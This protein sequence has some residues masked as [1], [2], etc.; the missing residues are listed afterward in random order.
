MRRPKRWG[1]AALLLGA[2]LPL[3]AWT[4]DDVSGLDAVSTTDER[5]DCLD[6]LELDVGEL[7]WPECFDDPSKAIG[8]RTRLRKEGIL[9]RVQQ[10]GRWTRVVRYFPLSAAKAE[11]KGQEALR[12]RPDSTEGMLAVVVDWDPDLR[13]FVWDLEAACPKGWHAAGDFKLTAYV[14]A[15]EKHF[16]EEERLTDPCEL[17]GEFRS[18]FLFGQ[19]VELQGS[20]LT[21][22]GRIVR[23]RADGCFE[24]ARCPLTA[25]TRCA[26]PGR[27]VAVD[28]DVIPLGTELLIEGVGRRKA[29]DVGGRIRGQHID[30]YYGTE[31]SVHQ[32][33]ALTVD[34]ALVCVPSNL[35]QGPPVPPRLRRR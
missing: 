15:Q 18:A 29:E 30:V 12:R 19:G 32:A 2:T 23:V 27:T 14:L 17:E 7:V 4:G 21:L 9:A 31:L 8:L 24:E 25:T 33:N 22:D 5:P 34:S 3:L 10:L 1:A 35:P 26:H 11:K 6:G 13:S 28:P 16:D 20:G